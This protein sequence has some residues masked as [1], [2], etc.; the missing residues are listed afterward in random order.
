MY[1]FF[2]ILQV[3]RSLFIA[4]KGTGFFLLH[5]YNTAAWQGYSE[6]FQRNIRLEVHDLESCGRITSNLSP[7]K[8]HC[9]K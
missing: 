6:I 8:L 7:G 4:E 1:F 9:C 5:R 2:L 3:K